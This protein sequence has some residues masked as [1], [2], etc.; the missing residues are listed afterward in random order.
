MATGP[1]TQQS[2]PATM[3]YVYDDANRLAGL[4]G[5]VCGWDNNGHSLT[6]GTGTYAYDAAK[7]LTGVTKGAS[8]F[9]FAYNGLG[10]R[11]RQTVN[12]APAKLTLD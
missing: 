3:T 6:D 12:G 2:L 4:N 11:L 9:A 8:T 1:L 7:R 5:V 10:D